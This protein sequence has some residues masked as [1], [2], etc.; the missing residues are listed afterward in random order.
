VAGDLQGGVGVV[1]IERDGDPGE[2]GVLAEEPFEDI[3][4]LSS[5]I[6]CG[7]VGDGEVVV[8]ER[9]RHGRGLLAA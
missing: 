6:G 1:G 3:D 2:V 5:L 9:G 8:E 7:L 4:G